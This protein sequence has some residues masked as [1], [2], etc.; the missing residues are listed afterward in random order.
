MAAAYR[1]AVSSDGCCPGGALD[2]THH[3]G[4]S[5]AAGAAAATVARDPRSVWATSGLVELTG[6]PD[7]PPLCPPGRAAVVAAELA[8][9]LVPAGIEL[10]GPALLGERA[11]KIGLTRRGAVSAGGSCRLL[12]TGDG[13]A[14]VSCARADDPDLLGAMVGAHLPPDP[15]PVIAAWLSVHSGAE[16]AE[17]AALLAVPVAPVEPNGA[18]RG[19][20][21]ATASS[22]LARPRHASGMLVVDFSALWAGPL[23]AHLLG[24]AGAQVVKVETPSR[25]D[26]ARYGDRDFYRLL[27]GGHRSVVLNPDVPRERAALTDLVA[28]ADVVVEASR[29]RALAGFGLDARATADSG[30]TWVSITAAGRA[31][32][33]IGFGDDVAAGAG[34]VARDADGPVFCGDALADP[35]TGL[36]AA[37]R[38][39]HAPAG[40]LIDISMSSVVAATL[41]PHIPTAPARRD[42]TTRVLD[43]TDGPVPVR[44]P[45][46]RR[47]RD[48]LVA[49]EPGADTA[50]VFAELGLP[51]P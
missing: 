17:R 31:A 21:T 20:A 46:A 19:L 40:A 14:A 38:A 2:K 44:P 5:E 39:L 3:R 27:H 34:L 11:A 6:R 29:P 30:T 9:K 18:S 48:D 50:A 8:A 37:V 28:A 41:D 43:T 49:P 23:C 25:P 42:G 51:S 22:D 10:D 35:L 26:G 16:V 45:R 4:D 12:P 47:L 33:R 7:G 1:C 13:W 32:D 24:L 15:W 36:T